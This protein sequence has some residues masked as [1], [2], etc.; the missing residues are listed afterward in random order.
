MLFALIGLLASEL[1]RSITH[2]PRDHPQGGPWQL[3]W[4][5]GY[6]FVVAVGVVLGAIQQW[7]P[8]ST[9]SRRMRVVGSA[10]WGVA[11]GLVLA[12]FVIELSRGAAYFF[13]P[14]FTDSPGKDELSRPYFGFPARSCQKWLQE[15]I[16]F[17]PI[18]MFGGVGALLGLRR[19][20]GE[21]SKR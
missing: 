4:Y 13:D 18:L 16:C 10:C 3:F 15:W 9:A 11:V 21:P 7:S 1:G 5:N 12:L 2:I 6:P 14:I 17:T 20:K 8:A 19:S